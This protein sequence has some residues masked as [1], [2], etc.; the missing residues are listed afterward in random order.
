LA[1]NRPE[2]MEARVGEKKGAAQVLEKVKPWRAKYASTGV[3]A[4]WP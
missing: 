3:R 4:F 1:E 2:R